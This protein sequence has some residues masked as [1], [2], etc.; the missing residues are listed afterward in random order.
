MNGGNDDEYTS[1]E[2]SK[3]YKSVDKT[4]LFDYLKK[5]MSTCDLPKK[6]G[7]KN[8]KKPTR[9]HRKKPSKNKTRKHKKYT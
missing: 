1:V 2:S 3:D 6:G 7:K 9:Q 5:E 8:K 4:D